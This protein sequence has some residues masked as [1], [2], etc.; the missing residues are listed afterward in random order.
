VSTVHGLHA[1]SESDTPRDL[2]DTPQAGT[3]AIRGGAIRVGGYGLCIAV[4]V[5]SSAMLLRHLGV[6]ATGSYVTVLSLASMAISV[7]DAGLA[8]IGVSELSTLPAERAQSFFRSLSGVRLV[9]ISC[10]MVLA[11]AFAIVSGFST[12]MVLGVVLAGIG[13][14]LLT[15]QTTYLL[16][17]V[18][19]LRLEW[20][21]VVETLRQ[22]G[23]AAAIVALVLL[24]APLLSFW[25]ATIPAGLATTALAAIL[26]RGS[27]P[28]LPA[29]D[30]AE[31]V[32]LVRRTMSYSLATA[33]GVIYFR[34]AILIMAHVTSGQQ[35]GYYAAPF[36]IIEVLFV[37]PQ[38]V[39][40]ST[41]PIIARAARDDRERLNYA[42][43]RT[44]EVSLL[45]GLAAGLA[46][47][48]GSH[49]I[50]GL[51]AGPQFAPAA[52]VLRVQGIALIATFV[53]A[54]FSY[55]LLSLGRYREVLS[56]NVAVLLLSGLLTG[57][58]ASSYG[59]LGAAWATTSME[60][61]Y[62]VLLAFAVVRAGA[63]PQVK[64]SRPLRAVLAASLGALVLLVPAIPDIA[65]PVL[66][67]AIY[68]VV[69]LVLG[70]VP[71]EL[72]EQVSGLRRSRS[73]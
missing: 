17:L 50:I 15:A 20:V 23:G 61:I 58:L 3:A 22:V 55:G 68:G 69:L 9:F 46:L 65:R 57:L 33:V 52:I 14:E 49:F 31:W 53:G 41:L 56:I 28:L 35:T 37:V 5:V 72:L 21:T 67:L 8:T 4:S 36:R 39:V 43:G 18:V 10:G 71:R 1:P 7:T 54:V 12:T 59:A 62:A 45:L 30:R 13:F 70:A 73:R 16:P 51:V 48:T 27:M 34:V 19:Q 47:V 32:P 29:F 40:G 2:L 25:A 26:I 63:R 60:G 11:T 64:L 66:A 24:G 38:L 6:V 44:F 42:L